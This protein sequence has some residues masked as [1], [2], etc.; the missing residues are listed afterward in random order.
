MATAPSPN[1]LTRQQLDELDALLQK[2]LSVP[3]PPDTPPLPGPAN[4]SSTG[5]NDH[6]VSAPARGGNESGPA[7]TDPPLPPSWRV[8][9]PASPRPASAPAGSFTSGAR[10][11][12]APAPHLALADPPSSVSLKL[13]PPVPSALT[14][15]PA[16][17]AP[18]K[19]V[20][21]TAP[22]PVPAPSLP[23]T[24][25]VVAPPSPKLAPAVAP[26][27]A[28][29]APKANSGLTPPPTTPPVPVPLL[30]FVMLNA[31]FDAGCGWLGPFGRVLRSGLFKQ[32]CGA[33][34]LALLVYTAAHLA[35]V[36]KWV[37][38]PV[39]LPWPQ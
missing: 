10:E 27:P 32:L 6:A 25:A 34:G 15:T 4:T 2:M 8:D 7:L 38:L 28:L 31:L 29:P 1:D 13:E 37:T 9:P 23:P 36:Q 17:A 14:Q 16:P 33:T 30:P 20:A 39:S 3:L 21:K 26:T 5:R 24:P 35:Q 22:A 12:S 11:G 18:L 19:P